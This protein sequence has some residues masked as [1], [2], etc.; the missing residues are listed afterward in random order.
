[1]FRPKELPTIK[2]DVVFNENIFVVAKVLYLKNDTNEFKFE[3]N[4][5]FIKVA[6]GEF[7]NL[8]VGGNPNF[9]IKERIDNSLFDDIFEEDENIIQE[10]V[11]KRN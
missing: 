5:W 10:E 2:Q 8:G 6:S 9:T 3:N 1:M 4:S 7:V 11:W